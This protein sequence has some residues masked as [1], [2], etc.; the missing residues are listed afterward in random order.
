LQFKL[1]GN[2]FES[3]YLPSIILVLEGKTDAKFIKRMAQI[4]F[5]SKTI[6]YVE[7]GNDNQV[8]P[9]VNQIKSVLGDIEKSPY[10][11]RIFVVLDR[12]HARSIT[13]GLT[14]R[15]IMAENIIEWNKN[16]IEF[17]YPKEI[18]ED[19]YSCRY[20]D[21]EAIDLT[22]ADRIT[23]NGITKTKDE[24]C[25]EVTSRLSGSMTFNQEFSEKLIDK[26]KEKVQ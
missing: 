7:A 2:T 12:T 22:G 3:L 16:G 24:L 18:I 8:I 1:L 9:A 15:G 19:I 13:T 23:I 14:R 26:L 4:L 25:E 17:Y 5:P 21:F 6:A 11:D 20:S 10:K